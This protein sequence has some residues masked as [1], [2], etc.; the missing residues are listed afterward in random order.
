MTKKIKIGF[1]WHNLSSSNYGVTALAVANIA[2]TLEAAKRV[3]VDLDLTTIGSKP[4]P[5][6]SSLAEAEA[7]F[8]RTIPHVVFSLKEALKAVARL[9]F[10]HFRKFRGY[11]LIIDIDEGDSFTDIYGPRRF[12]NHLAT[13]V[14]TLMSG[15]PLV[16]APQ[17]IGPFDK[18]LSRALAY[19]VLRRAYRVFSRD[20]RSTA[21][22][23]SIGI[24]VFDTTDVAFALPYA[25]QPRQA[26]TAGV[27]VSGLLY[28]GGYT[29]NNQFALTLDYP[30]LCQDTVKF[31]RSRGMQVHL[32]GHVISGEDPVE[33][34]YRA[35]LALKA[36]F[37]D[38]DGVVV[39]PRFSSPLA[40][41]GYISGLAFFTGA[42]MHATIGAFSAGVPTVPIAYS[43]KFQGVFGSLGHGDTID[44]KS[45]NNEEAIALLQKRFDQYASGSNEAQKRAL[46]KARGRNEEYTSELSEIVSCLAR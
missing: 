21:Y 15:V 35:C 19:P 43:R 39:A 27:N 30:K 1:V 40:A 37:K 42:R 13:K 20:E 9:D 12:Y 16:L 38:D 7:S 10:S 44:A 18:S 11:D 31:L 28:S 14:L 45:V 6:T 22:M 36:L 33:D 46:V 25:S 32:I 34:D 5:G 3:G 4:T 29:G 26:N 2:M 17:T 23:K 41:K 24:D 8:D